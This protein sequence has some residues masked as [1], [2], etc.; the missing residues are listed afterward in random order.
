MDRRRKTLNCGKTDKGVD[1]DKV[2]RER[3]IKTAI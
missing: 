1:K 2:E 3:G